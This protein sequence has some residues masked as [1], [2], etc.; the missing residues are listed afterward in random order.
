MDG[1]REGEREGVRKEGWPLIGLHRITED[2]WDWMPS[3]P[4]SITKCNEG[5]EGGKGEA[6]K[7]LLINYLKLW[8]IM[9][10]NDLLPALLHW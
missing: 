5:G 3:S 1:G 8:I 10:A 9:P 4:F 6:G 2:G 7:F